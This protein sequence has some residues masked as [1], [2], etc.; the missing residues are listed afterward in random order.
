MEYQEANKLI[1]SISLKIH[2][3]FVRKA[4]KTTKNFN[5]QFLIL[6]GSIFALSHHQA[7]QSVGW[8]KPTMYLLAIQAMF[9][10]ENFSK[11]KTNKHL[12]FLENKLFPKIDSK[13]FRNKSR[14]YSAT[15]YQLNSANYSWK[16]FFCSLS[17]LKQLLNAES[18]VSF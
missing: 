11:G 17:L 2:G 12:T 15:N 14:K 13:K 16:V 18:L 4:A 7:N 5:V 9:H 6:I 10:S 3:M 8:E 1:L